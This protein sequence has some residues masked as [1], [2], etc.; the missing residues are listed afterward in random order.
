MSSK[1]Y[2]LSPLAETDLEEIWLYTLNHWSLEQADTYI[3][4][5]VATFEA[6]AA[7]TK[8]GRPADIR[9]NYQKYLCGS[10]MI[11]FLY[12]SDR[13]DIIRILHQRQ[14]ATLHLKD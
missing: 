7:G 2:R 13:M 6:L 14:D 10:H 12:Y 3:G 11:Y 4:S 8:R 1:H 9:P 5:L